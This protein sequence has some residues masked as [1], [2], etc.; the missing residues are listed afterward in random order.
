[1]AASVFERC[2]FLYYLNENVETRGVCRRRVRCWIRVHVRTPELRDISISY[3]RMKS[4]KGRAVLQRE[5][6]ERNERAGVNSYSGIGAAAGCNATSGGFH[7]FSASRDEKKRRRRRREKG[8]R[9][10]TLWPTARCHDPPQYPT[11][12]HLTLFQQRA[13]L[14]NPLAPQPLALALSLFLS[15]SRHPFHPLNAT[16]L[17]LSGI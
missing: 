17:C 9:G 4:V 5:G 8:G 15:F 13:T 7:G 6:C 16:K 10:L 12:F 11:P 14:L 1:M 2:E 3:I